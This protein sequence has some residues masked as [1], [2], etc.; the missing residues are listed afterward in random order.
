VEPTCT[1]VATGRGPVL[2]DG[3]ALAIEPLLVLGR[4]GTALLGD[5]WTVVTKDRRPSAHFE[6]TIA[7]TENGPEILTLP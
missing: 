5:G 7:V 2:A 1:L 6:H 3:M 4:P